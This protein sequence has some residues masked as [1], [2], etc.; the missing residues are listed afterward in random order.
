MRKYTIVLR[1]IKYHNREA[2]QEENV[3]QNEKK[4]F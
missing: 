3:P 1:F 2:T 4:D